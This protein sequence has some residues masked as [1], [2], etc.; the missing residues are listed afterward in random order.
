MV[1]GI[2]FQME[3]MAVCNH[4]QLAMAESG[5]GGVFFRIGRPPLP[6]RGEQE[7]DP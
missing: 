7:V 4:A 6:R 3:A 5:V 2:V 1:V